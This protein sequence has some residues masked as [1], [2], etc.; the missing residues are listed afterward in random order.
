M[1]AEDE[2]AGKIAIYPNPSDGL[3]QVT[4]PEDVKSLSIID[5]SGKVLLR[6]KG[7]PNQLELNL[8]HLNSGI[9][10]IKVVGRNFIESRRIIID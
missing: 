8:K 5:L 7:V 6:L 4:L 9:Y 3:M 1:N 10:L 2:L